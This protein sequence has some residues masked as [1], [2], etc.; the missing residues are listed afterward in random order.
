MAVSAGRLVRTAPVGVHAKGL[1][2]GR[3][4]GRVD[5]GAWGFIRSPQGM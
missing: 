1:H 3:R 2:D 5:R 4:S